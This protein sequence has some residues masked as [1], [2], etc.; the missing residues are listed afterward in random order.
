MR[1]S[2]VRRNRPSR[3]GRE[4][5]KGRTASRPGEPR[6]PSSWAGR[7]ARTAASR[8]SAGACPSAPASR[9]RGQQGGGVTVQEAGTPS[10]LSPDA[11][12]RTVRGETRAEKARGFTGKGVPH[13][14]AGST[15]VREPRVTA[16]RRG[17]AVPALMPRSWG[18]R[19]LGRVRLSAAP[20]TP[21]QAGPARPS[22]TPG[23]CSGS[24]PWRR[25]GQPPRARVSGF[26][27]ANRSESGSFTHCAAGAPFP[28]S[29]SLAI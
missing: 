17:S 4:E 13:P 16:L 10:A 12:K 20:G 21:Q 8:P 28:F 23:A 9:G 15:G 6:A 18:V 5:Q 19:S 29:G 27:P 3:R 22:P 26:P 7:E 11:R 25:G 24:R 2:T 14:R 1:S